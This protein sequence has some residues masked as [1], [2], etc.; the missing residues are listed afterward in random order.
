VRKQDTNPPYPG[1][2]GLT[3]RA[4]HFRKIFSRVK[5]A[6][7]IVCLYLASCR[8]YKASEI[9]LLKCR[10][11]NTTYLEIWLIPLAGGGYRPMLLYTFRKLFSCATFAPQVLPLYWTFYTLF[12]FRVDNT[13]NIFKN[14]T[15]LASGGS[16]IGLPPQT[17]PWGLSC[18][19]CQFGLAVCGHVGVAT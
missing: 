12:S 5:F 8:S 10:Y 15:Y 9:T 11:N 16:Y 2:G 18:I 1:R 3:L 4:I 13:G 17:T 19:M 14:S 6:S 7:Q